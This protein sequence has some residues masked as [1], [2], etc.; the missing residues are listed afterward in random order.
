MAA[1]KATKATPKKAAKK[2]STPARR[3]WKEVFLAAL[4]TSPNVSGAAVAAGHNRQHVYAVR[5]ADAA[6]ADAWD[7]A[8]GEAVEMAEGEAYRR[9][10]KGVEKPVYQAG[11]L[12]GKVQEYSDTLL[13]FLLKAHKPER[14]RESLDLNLRK[15]KSVEDM[16]DEELAAIAA[17][18]P[19]SGGAGTH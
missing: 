5:E 4:R 7:D 1:K 8:L 13:I 16:T 14:Y 15:P 19:A 18:K 2:H 10:V 3:D 12:I 9:A 11:H 6:F 17:G